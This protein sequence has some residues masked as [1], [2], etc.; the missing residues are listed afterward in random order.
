MTAA[1]DADEYVIIG[2]GV[3]GCVTSYLLTQQGHAVTIIEKDSIG[4]LLRNIEFSDGTYCDSAPHILFYA[5]E[6]EGEVADLFERF[7]T[8]RDETFY[9]KTYPTGDL[10]EPHDYPVSEANIERWND[11]DAIRKERASLTPPDDAATFEA[12]VK[13]RVGPTLYRRY[14]GPYTEKHWGVDPDRV[15][16]DWFD[17]KMNFPETEESFF[18][19]SAAVYPSRTYEA[20][21]NEMVAPN[22]VRHET[23][24]GLDV[25]DS[26]VDAVRTDERTRITGD[27][28]IN[29]IDPSIVADTDTELVYRSMV[30]IGVRIQSATSLFP[31]HVDWGYFPR[32][33]EF[34]RVTDYGFT[35]QDLAPDDHILTFEFPCFRDDPVYD[36]DVSRYESYLREFFADQDLRATIDEVQVRRAPRAYPL[37]VREQIDRFESINERLDGLSGLYNLGRVAMYEYIWIKDIVQQAI[38][39]VEDTISEEAEL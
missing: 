12:Y 33:Y 6:T 23:V 37:P 11:A 18:E 9:A 4:G 27:K 3:A 36:W 25:S 35:D 17:F 5:H 15:T 16:G 21:L 20:I 28:F 32:D 30:I 34:T 7:A 31:D 2:G 10:N 26:T 22:T 24:T 29:T 19:G 14:F 38:D 39:A 1:T 8:L 13:P